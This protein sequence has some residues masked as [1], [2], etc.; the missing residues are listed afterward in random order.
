MLDIALVTQVLLNDALKLLADKETFF[1]GLHL[2]DVKQYRVFLLHSSRMKKPWSPQ[3]FEQGR[4][5]WIGASPETDQLQ[6]AF[7]E[8]PEGEKVSV[9]RGMI[10]Y[11]EWEHDKAPPHV[12]EWLEKG[13]VPQ[14][15][16]IS[17]RN[18]IPFRRKKK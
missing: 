9:I 5:V 10:A 14:A 16:N 2:P 3:V 13:T 1:H 4:F 6:L 11:E 17:R 7:S 18:V 15:D 12:L 8:F